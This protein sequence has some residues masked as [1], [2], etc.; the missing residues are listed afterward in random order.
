MLQH[1]CSLQKSSSSNEM[2]SLGNPCCILL[3][4]LGWW[5]IHNKFEYFTF[6]QQNINIQVMTALCLD[7]TMVLMGPGSRRRG[8]CGLLFK[9]SFWKWLKQFETADVSVWQSPNPIYY[10]KDKNRTKFKSQARNNFGWQTA[11]S[12]STI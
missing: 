7:Q 5:Q 9:M 11:S 2:P 10:R 3:F 4:T 1:C 8:F 12:I 6:C